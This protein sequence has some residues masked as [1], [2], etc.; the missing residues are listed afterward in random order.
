MK[1][2]ILFF[3]IICNIQFNQFIG[4]SIIDQGLERPEDKATPLIPLIVLHGKT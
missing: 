3:L 2:Y 4:G 1:T